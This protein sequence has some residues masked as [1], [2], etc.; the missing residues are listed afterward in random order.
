MV[1]VVS[2][3][4]II[5]IIILLIIGII[6]IFHP[7]SVNQAFID[8][9]NYDIIRQI[10][11]FVLFLIPVVNVIVSFLFLCLILKYLI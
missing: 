5:T 8:F 3:L 2:S 7:E 9:T 11:L 10:S 6:S 1:E 4:F